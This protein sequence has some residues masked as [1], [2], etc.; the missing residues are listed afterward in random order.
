MRLR[1]ASLHIVTDLKLLRDE[2]RKDAS[3]SSSVL[4]FAALHTLAI[5][6]FPEWVARLDERTGFARSS[7]VPDNLHDCVELLSTGACDFLICYAHPNVPMLLDPRHFLATT[8][9]SDELIP[10][11]APE[12]ACSAEKIPY[13]AYT[14]D[15]FLGQLVDHLIPEPL[16]EGLDLRYQN[17]MAEALKAMALRKLGLAWIPASLLQKELASSALQIMGPNE[18]RTTLEIR[19][20]R[21]AE[22]G[23]REVERF[24]RSV[25]TAAPAR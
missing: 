7:M 4:R 9:A 6:F 25:N 22:H 14:P 1:D 10:V 11:V 21:R 16:R 18:W 12:I 20:Y 23:R 15:S 24:W 17:S 19:L 5:T 8:L 3:A 2:L 13:L